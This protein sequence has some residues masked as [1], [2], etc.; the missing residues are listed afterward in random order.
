MN[1]QLQRKEAARKKQEKNRVA[2]KQ[3]KIGGW[4]S[5]R[6]ILCGALLQWHTKSVPP[7][8]HQES[9]TVRKSTWRMPLE[10][11][12]NINVIYGAKQHRGTTTAKTPRDYAL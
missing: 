4:P 5:T 12:C 7:I 11:A 9:W 10:T 2:Q 3:E 1:T 8:L 6:A